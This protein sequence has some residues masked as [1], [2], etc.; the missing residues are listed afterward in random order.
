MEKRQ[1]IYLYQYSFL[2]V[3]ACLSNLFI[4]GA[5]EGQAGSE[6]WMAFLFCFPLGLLVNLLAIGLFARNPGCTLHDINIRAF[7]KILG[8][9]ATVLYTLYFFLIS[10]ILLNYYGLYTVDTVLVQM[11][12][13]F[14]I[15][16]VM[17]AVAY[18]AKKG[19]ETLGRMSV[20]VGAVI[21][22]VCIAAVV[23]EIAT[24]EPEHLLPILAAPPE[25]MI[26][27]V[28]ALTTI[29][30]GELLAVMT[31]VPNVKER[32]KLVKPTLLSILAGNGLVLLFAVGNILVGGQTAYMNTV[33]FFRASQST[34]LF[35]A[36]NGVKMLVVAAFFFA[37]VFR[38][39]IHL[40]AICQC[41]AETFH[42]ADQKHLALP[43]GAL[44]AGFAQ[45]ISGS[46]L[47]VSRFL[48]QVYPYIAVVPQVGLPAL[49]LCLTWRKQKKEE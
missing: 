38:L 26:Q 23:F 21:L 32:K 40:R 35:Q 6:T 29:E 9:I 39:T 17:L 27:V 1:K 47:E 30:F 34:E 16:P 19:I 7:G 12:L 13:I 8:N 10:A 36:I 37:V 25:K 41:L 31:C 22:V 24:G 49:A 42:L 11:R 48:V 28:L 44:V 43:V 20:I 18:T 3:L 14:F 46:S 33:G 5:V 4:I 2:L 15:A 45:F